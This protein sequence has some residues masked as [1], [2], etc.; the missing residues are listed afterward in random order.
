M[1]A[2]Y[3]PDDGLGA[4]IG[5]ELSLALLSPAWNWFGGY[6]DTVYDTGTQNVRSSV[7]LELG[8]RYVGVDAGYVLDASDPDGLRHGVVVR[9]MLTTGLLSLGSRFGYLMT[10]QTQLF[11]EAG[12]LVKYPIDLDH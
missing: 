8:S 9:P 3:F 4:F 6:V 1:G 10:G 2:S 12:L 11:F 5:A 7:G